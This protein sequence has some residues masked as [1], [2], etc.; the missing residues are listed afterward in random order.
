MDLEDPVLRGRG[1]AAL[2]ILAIF[3]CHVSSCIYISNFLGGVHRQ[4]VVEGVVFFG[5]KTLRDNLFYVRSEK[6]K[7]TVEDLP[8]SVF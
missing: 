8:L 2:I 5:W 3:V 4:K 1:L 7:P 6:I